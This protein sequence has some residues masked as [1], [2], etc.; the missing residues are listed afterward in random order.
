[1]NC[2]EYQEQLMDLA[3]GSREDAVAAMEHVRE[4]EECERCLLNQRTLSTGLRVVAN[5][6]TA[7][8]PALLEA[9]LLVHCDARRKPFALFFKWAV[10]A[11]AAGAAAMFLWIYF[12]P[13]PRAIEAPPLVAR[14]TPELPVVTVAAPVASGK[15]RRTHFATP[16]PAPAPVARAVETPFIP[17]PYA[18]PLLPTEQAEIVKV[19]LSAGALA[20]FGMTVQ[21][22]DPSMRL[23]AELVLG[24][25]GLA[26]A[27]RIVH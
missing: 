5:C 16:T 23:N 8:P 14:K 21:G 20:S 27:V 2:E 12:T 22:A 26:R 13:A 3:R 7:M 24:E 17:V 25:N 19:N 9:R 15:H 4:C 10:P 18:S 1:M 11:L 6:E